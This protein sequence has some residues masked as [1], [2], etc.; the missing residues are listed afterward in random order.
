CGREFEVPVSGHIAHPAMAERDD[1][2]ERNVRDD[3]GFFLCRLG[4][5][6]ACDE[7]RCEGEN[8]T[9]THVGSELVRP[10][11][12]KGCARATM[13][14]PRCCLSTTIIRGIRR[15]QVSA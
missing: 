14:Y 3:A 7:E 1:R 11:A 15:R 6:I 12:C 9:F 5:C 10:A 2:S 13:V 8:E 4:K